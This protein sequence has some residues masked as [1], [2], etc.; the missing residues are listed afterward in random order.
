MAANEAATTAAPEANPWSK[1]SA[2]AR[3]V[4]LILLRARI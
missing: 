1:T 4:E 2:A 3:V